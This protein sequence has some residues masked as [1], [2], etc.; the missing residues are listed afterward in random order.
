MGPLTLGEYDVLSKSLASSKEIYFYFNY[1]HMYTK[2]LTSFGEK[3]CLGRQRNV[4]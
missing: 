4:K 1:V 2:H 3:R